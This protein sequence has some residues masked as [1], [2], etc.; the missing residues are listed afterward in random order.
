MQLVEVD[1]DLGPL[2]RQQDEGRH[3]LFRRW[4]IRPVIDPGFRYK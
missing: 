1:D 3:D 2:D 4:S